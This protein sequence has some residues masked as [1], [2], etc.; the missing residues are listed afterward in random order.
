M[1]HPF[2]RTNEKESFLLRNFQLIVPKNYLLLNRRA[3]KQ[4]V[5]GSWEQDFASLKNKVL[6]THTHTH[7]HVRM[8][9]E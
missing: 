6:P 5:R 4:G 2:R 7:T 9:L 3:G 1:K 8:L